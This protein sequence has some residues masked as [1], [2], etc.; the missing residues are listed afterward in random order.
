ML[1]KN[2]PV[3]GN[4]WGCMH[5]AQLHCVQKNVTTSSAI[6]YCLLLRVLAIDRCFYFST[7]PISCTYFNLGKLS[8][9]QQNLK[10]ENFIGRCNFDLKSLSKQYDARKT[11]SEFLDN[12]WKVGSIDSLLKRIRKTGTV[13]WREAVEDLVLSQQDKPKRH[14]S[15]RE[16]SHETAIL[17]SRVHRIIHLDLQLK[18]FI[19]LRCR[20]QVLSE[21]NCITRPTR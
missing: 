11:L 13:V 14:L 8:N 6:T 1:D 16:I 10:N 17:H 4:P 3:T 9:L 19:R 12:G 20:A 7:L 21:A 5:T 15:A 18:C 2:L